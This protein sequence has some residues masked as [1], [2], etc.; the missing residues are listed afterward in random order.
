MECCQLFAFTAALCPAVTGRHIKCRLVL[1]VMCA[2][3]YS[4]SQREGY[5]P[6]FKVLAH[7][8]VG[9]HLSGGEQ[10]TSEKSCN[11]SVGGCL[12]RYLF[13]G[14]SPFTSTL[15]CCQHVGSLGRQQ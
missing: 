7:H 2:G 1:D 15:C 12:C 8:G 5:L 11:V 10:R 3:Y 9:V 13:H 4:T 14:C 6:V